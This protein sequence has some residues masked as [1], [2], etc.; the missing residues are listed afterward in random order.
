MSRF[1]VTIYEVHKQ[2]VEVDANSDDEAVQI[3]KDG[4]G[5]YVGDP[6]YVDTLRDY[7]WDVE[8]ITED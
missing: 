8:E 3:V 5:E 1:E 4:G 6:L 2:Y 7:E